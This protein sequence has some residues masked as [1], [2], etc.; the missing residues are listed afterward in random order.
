M[1][2]FYSCEQR[3]SESV[4]AYASRLDDLFDKAVSLGAARRGDIGLVK[5]TFVSSTQA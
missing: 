3:S 4:L 5:D 1:R 2:K